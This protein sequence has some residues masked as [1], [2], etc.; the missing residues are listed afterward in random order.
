MRPFLLA[1]SLVALG[2]LLTSAAAPRAH[3]C[4][5]AAL[6][7]TEYVRQADVVAIGKVIRLTTEEAGAQPPDEDAIV[8]VE[9]YLKGGGAREIAVDDPPS[10]ASCGIFDA[11]SLGKRYLLFLTGE[12]SPFETNLCSRTAELAG[13]PGD[14]QL[15]ED[16]AAITGS[17]SPPGEGF[18]WLPVIAPAAV[19]G[20]VLLG[21]S[22]FVLRRRIIGAG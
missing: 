16:V 20:A 2:G 21:A 10:S 7:P 8:L 4:S 19:F 14:Q 9:R 15:L 5:C 11:G 12:T 6:T 1:L 3:A 22:A 13:E 17:G 18:P